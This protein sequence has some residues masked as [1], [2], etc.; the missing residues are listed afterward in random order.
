MMPV[1][2]QHDAVP[3]LK[4]ALCSPCSMKVV[5]LICNHQEAVRFRPGA[6][7]IGALRLSPYLVLHSVLP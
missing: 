5:Q 4:S 1:A 3:E 7:S 6:P 2:R